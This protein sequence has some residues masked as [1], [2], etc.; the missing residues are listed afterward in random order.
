MEDF[1]VFLIQICIVHTTNE[2]Y[3]DHGYDRSHWIN[4]Q[5]FIRLFC[6]CK[7]K[8]KSSFIFLITYALFKKG[9]NGNDMRVSYFRVY[10]ISVS[11]RRLLRFMFNKELCNTYRILNFTILSNYFQY[12]RN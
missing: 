6:H 2:F 9:V 8:I 12:R 1:S 11:L 5:I 10:W 3:L 7:K 4:I